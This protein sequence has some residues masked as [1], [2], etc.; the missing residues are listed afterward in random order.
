VPT[1]GFNTRG[2]SI[3]PSCHMY[4]GVKKMEVVVT[5][6]GGRYC[7]CRDNWHPIALTTQE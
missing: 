3:A 4:D 6:M 2:G 5:N 1:G 7:R